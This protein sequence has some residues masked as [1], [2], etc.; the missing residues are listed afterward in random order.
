MGVKNDSVLCLPEY[1]LDGRKRY[2]GIARDNDLFHS[3][4]KESI[5][6]NIYIAFGMVEINPAG[7]KHIIGVLVEP[8][9]KV[10]TQGKVFPTDFERQAGISGV[11]AER[12]MMRTEFGTVAFSICRDQWFP[13]LCP[14]AEILLHPRG[15][16]LDSI[17]HG[18][19]Y[20]KWLMLDR[21]TA[22]LKR[23]YVVGTTGKYDYGI[24]SDIVDFEGNIISESND[25]ALIS[26][27]LD[28]SILREYRN[29]TY[30][31]KNKTVPRFWKGI[32]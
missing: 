27:E 7:N 10:Q 2:D 13:E 12:K 15:F 25:G 6:R 17:E 14:D 11:K 32:K 4:I 26:A 16:G 18:Q 31:P 3:I 21:T 19:F 1:F 22:M 30:S 20:D 5:Q 8:S 29:C 28:L 9:G 23:S 24:L